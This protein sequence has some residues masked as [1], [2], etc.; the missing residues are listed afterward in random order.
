MHHLEKKRLKRTALQKYLLDTWKD[1]SFHGPISSSLRSYACP[2][3]CD[4][5]L[6]FRPLTQKK[7]L[8][9]QSYK[10]KI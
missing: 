2:S 9:K 7:T 3:V 8:H 4:S 1:Y 6:V 10:K 5:Q